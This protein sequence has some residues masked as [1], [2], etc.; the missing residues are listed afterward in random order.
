MALFSADLDL[1]PFFVLREKG[2]ELVVLYLQK[3]GGP[4]RLH[5]I[6]VKSNLPNI[7]KPRRDNYI[8][9]ESMPV[10]GSGKLDVISLKKFALSAKQNSS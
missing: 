10:L 3:A 4:E 2:E 8:R 5:N 9:I 7:W 1:L 6:I